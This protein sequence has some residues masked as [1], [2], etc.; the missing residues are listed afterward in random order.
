MFKRTVSHLPEADAAPATRTGCEPPRKSQSFDL[1]ALRA[2]SEKTRQIGPF[3]P[4]PGDEAG[5]ATSPLTEQAS[6]KPGHS[7]PNS[8]DRQFRGKR[9]ASERP[10]DS[11]TMQQAR[12]MRAPRNSKG[13]Q[14]EATRE[15]AHL[16]EIF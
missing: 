11:R 7:E 9:T 13:G 3:K 10:K 5:G 15:D 1:P 4:W 6:E 12:A 14:L 2:T 8:A 16:P